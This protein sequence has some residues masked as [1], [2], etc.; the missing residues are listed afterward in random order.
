MGSFVYLCGIATFFGY[1]LVALAALKKQTFR[2]RVGAFSV[3]LESVF[4]CLLLSTCL[5][6]V[7]IA[8]RF[9]FPK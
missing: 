8:V 2:Q 1:S 3:L 9:V 7:F 6:F 5:F 4:L